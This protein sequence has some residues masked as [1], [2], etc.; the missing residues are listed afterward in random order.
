MEYA[1]LQVVDFSERRKIVP[2][3]A[4]GSMAPDTV[5]SAD[6]GARDKNMRSRELFGV[7]R[8][9]W[10]PC[11]ARDAA[12]KKCCVKGTRGDLA[13]D[14]GGGEGISIGGDGRIRTAA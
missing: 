1:W 5:L 12:A 7:E 8:I 2:S 10:E 3:W 4:N 6:E 13:V 9:V 14:W 11:R